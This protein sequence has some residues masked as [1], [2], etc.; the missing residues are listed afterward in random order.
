MNPVIWTPTDPARTNLARF[1]RGLPYAELHRRSL[2]H[3]GAFW[4]D[5]W[6][7][8][9]VI[10]DPGPGP[11]FVPGPHMTDAAWFPGAKLNFAENLLRP[12][13]AD[14]SPAILFRSELGA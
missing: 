1:A 3:P 10:G 9:E 2:D 6:R 4:T 12:A 11:A 8:A 7:F 14:D 5:V 13:E